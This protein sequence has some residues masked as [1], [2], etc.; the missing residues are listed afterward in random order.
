M[1]QGV[2]LVFLSSF[3]RLRQGDPLPL[4]LFVMGMEVLNILLQSV[5]AD[6]FTSGCR[7]EGMMRSISVSL[8]YYLLMTQLCS[9]RLQRTICF[10]YVGC[11]FGLKIILDNSELI[12]VGMVDNAEVLAT[13]LGC[14]I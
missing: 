7:I 9:V 2:S 14:Q 13:E 12:P 5:M 1:R 11:F 4:C 8:I 6:G 10:T 3:K